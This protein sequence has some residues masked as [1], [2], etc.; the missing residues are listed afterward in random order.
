[1]IDSSG[2]SGRGSHGWQPGV[3]PLRPLRLADITD[4]AVATLRRHAAVVFGASALVALAGTVLVLLAEMYV[5]P[6]RR[7]WQHPLNELLANAA[8]LLVTLSTHALVVGVTTVVV[9]RAVLGRPVSAREVWAEV[10]PRLLA[11]FGLTAVVTVVTIVGLLLLVVPGIVAYVFLSLAVPVLMWE[12]GT[13][14]DGL[15]RS[16]QLVGGAWWRVF[17]VLVVALLITVLVSLVV[18]LLFAQLLPLG[19]GTSPLSDGT[20]A[21]HRLI[22]GLGSVAGQSLAVPFS[23]A[24]TVLIYLDRRM[25]RENLDGELRRAAE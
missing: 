21:G 9:G 25:R 8:S 1:M 19:A 18:Q 2:M 20:P 16:V 17:G 14:V 24:V 13:V 3:I 5:L 12:R 6:L 22:L 4:G 15:A 23:S 10:G 11:L 7:S